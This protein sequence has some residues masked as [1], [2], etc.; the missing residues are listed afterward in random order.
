[1]SKTLFNMVCEKAEATYSGRPNDLAQWH[2]HWI[3]T[4]SEM[5]ASFYAEGLTNT[6]QT[7]EEHLKWF[8]GC[9]AEIRNRDMNERDK[10]FK[11]Q[12]AEKFGYPV[13]VF[14]SFVP[15]NQSW[16]IFLWS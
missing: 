12:W 2:R 8:D 15:T 16:I 11:L 13:K 14:K 5:I 1:M 3:D 9:M 6:A 4:C 10:L 7:L